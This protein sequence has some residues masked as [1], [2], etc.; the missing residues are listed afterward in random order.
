[1]LTFQVQYNY[2]LQEEHMPFNVI[3]RSGNSIGILADRFTHNNPQSQL[4]M[5]GLTKQR[6]ET[7]DIDMDKIRDIIAY[8]LECK[9]MLGAIKEEK[10]NQKLKEIWQSEYQ[11]F[12]YYNEDFLI[13]RLMLNRSVPIE[14]YIRLDRF[15]FDG[16]ILIDG[17]QLKFASDFSV[18]LDVEMDVIASPF[19]F[20]Q[21]VA[22]FFKINGTPQIEI[23][24]IRN[25]QPWE[26]NHVHSTTLPVISGD[27]STQLII[28]AHCSFKIGMNIA[29]LFEKEKITGIFG[30]GIYYKIS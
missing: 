17:T 10:F 5:V 30:D 19:P 21:G 20:Q 9:T 28:Q 26:M 8:A 6:Y 3:D 7:Y 16:Y 23:Q 22:I 29:V 2:M 24:T 4:F 11:S 25:S 14:N 12:G 15:Q 1:M 27:V 13:K 18:I